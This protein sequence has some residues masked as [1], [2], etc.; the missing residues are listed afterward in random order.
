[1]LAVS[2]CPKV[3]GR[4]G[5]PWLF[6]IRGRAATAAMRSDLRRTDLVSLLPCFGLLASLVKSRCEEA[7]FQPSPTVA[8]ARERFF[9]A[10]RNG[11]SS[12]ELQQYERTLPIPIE[13]SSFCVF[14]DEGFAIESRYL[15]RSNEED[16]WA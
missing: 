10:V 14:R 4:S 8:P 13:R 9:S 5:R 3:V 2:F 6:V 7:N 15:I 16:F 1:M 12:R 11:L